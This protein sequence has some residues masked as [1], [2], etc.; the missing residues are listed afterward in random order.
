MMVRYRVAWA[1]G[2]TALVAGLSGC[3]T[4]PVPLAENFALT[5]Q[6]KVRSAGHWELVARDVVDRTAAALKQTGIASGIDLHVVEP[7]NPT[8]FESAFRQFLITELVQAGMSVTRSS[9]SPI[10]VSY[11]A[12]LI[13][14]RSARPDFVPGRYTMLASGIYAL[15]G[16]R[17]Q[18]LDLKLA[19]GV[20]LAGA[21][22]V[23]ASM[24]SGGPTHTE[25][26][27]TTTVASGGHYLV[28]NT[29]VY[30]LEDDD[31]FLFA[32]AESARP[33]KVLEVVGE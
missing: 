10:E 26:I 5:T 3:A 23:A 25:L 16:L 4:S 27:L 32:Q 18:H 30:Y 28:R 13:R 2:V 1:L 8:P 31:A 7:S 15:R 33:L 19:A 14:H 24:S 6:K 29:D 22:D 9:D 17:G 12:T 11:E 20:A 21:A